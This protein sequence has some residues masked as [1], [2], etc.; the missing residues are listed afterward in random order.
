MLLCAAWSTA[1]VDTSHNPAS[2]PAA[3]SAAPAAA[4]STSS[5]APRELR[6]L[7]DQGT[8]NSAAYRIGPQDV[9]DI[10]V[11][12][13][14]DLS[15][16]VQ[17]GDSGMISMPLIGDVK[18]AG[19]TPQSLERT[20]VARYGAQYVRSPQITVSIKEFN[21]QR[22]TLDGAFKKPGIIPYRG[23][24]TLVQAVANAGNFDNDVA[25]Q[26][27]LIFRTTDGAR[28]GAKFDL[29]AIRDGRIPDPTL[30]PG[31]VIVA[32]TSGTKVMFNNVMKVVGP[33]TGFA[34]LFY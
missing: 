15:R 17:V 32:A 20:L 13:V 10:S 34:R 31:D 4:S 19:Q 12:Q 21:S 5:A 9:L 29:D 1:C 8:P 33:A 16:T 23:N 26:T 6:A 11:F 27:V 2:A 28:T 14:Q 7:A 25:D 3:Q 30:Q 22:I 18:A 24:I